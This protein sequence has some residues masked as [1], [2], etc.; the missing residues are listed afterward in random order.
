MVTR[1]LWPGPKLLTLRGLLLL[2]ILAIA[3]P[4]QGQEEPRSR[5]G[6]SVG[7]VS[8]IGLIF[9]QQYDW[10]SFELTVGTWSFRDLSV[11][12]VHKQYFSSGRVLG[13]AGAGLWTVLA[14]PPDGR[15]G[16]A[17]LAR[18]PLGMEWTVSQ[19]HFLNVEIGLNRALMIRR[20]DP[21]DNLPPNRRLVPLPGAS[22]RW[23]PER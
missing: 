1:I 2:G 10:G 11:S 3:R 7:G 14:F 22:Y 12:L 15:T 4:T 6:L 9:E 16:V 21:T 18:M 23:L 17:V 20:T 13:V 8:T 19:E 5:V